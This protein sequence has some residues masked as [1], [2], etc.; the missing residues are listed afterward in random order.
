MRAL[1]VDQFGKKTGSD[2]LAV[3]ELINTKE[4]IETSVYLSDDT[5]VPHK[6]YSVK[7][8]FGFHNV[9]SGNIISKACKYLKA[10]KELKKH[11]IKNNYDV[12]NLQWFS[13]PWIEKRFIKAIKKYSN[14][15]ITVHDVIPFDK[16]I[17]EVKALKGIYKQA[18]YLLVHTKKAKSDFEKVYGASFKV[19]IITQG[20]C[21]K[22]EYFITN[23][24]EAREKLGLPKDALIYLFYGTIR[25]S[26]GLPFMLEAMIKAHAQDNK[27]FLLCA[28]EMHKVDQESISE[29]VKFLENE[30]AGQF[31]FSYVPRELEPYYFSASDVLCLPYTEVTQSGV[32]QLG[33]MYELPLIATNVGAMEE[34][35]RND[36]NGYL[37]EKENADALCEVILKMR[38]EKAR[39]I[40]SKVSRQIAIN[41]FSL[42]K[43]AHLMAEAYKKSMR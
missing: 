35:V 24:K 30:K 31:F 43:K 11:I 42:D 3:A 19:Q 7:I 33:L 41:D 8:H 6:D 15:V 32:A 40:F 1:I 26:K 17:G 34:V 14:V 18:D 4:G 21:N 12:V 39:E 13:L 5:E 16:R 27:I 9:Y 25:R 28:G 36:E 23:K 38:D 10:L 20:F 29:Q 22:N 2:T 37:I